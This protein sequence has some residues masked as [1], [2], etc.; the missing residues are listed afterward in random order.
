MEEWSTWYHYLLACTLPR[1]LEAS[2][3]PLLESL[4]TGFIA[5]YPNGVHSAPYKTFREDTLLTLGR[6]LMDRSCWEGTE[7][8]V[9]RILH[10]SNN[11]PARIW[12]W[13]DACGDFSS[14]M[15]FC[16][17]YLPAALI[18]NWLRS[19][20]A[21]KS[22]HWRAQVLV[23]MVGAHGILAGTVKWPSELKIGARP[24]VSWEWSHCLRPDLAEG[25]ASGANITQT[26]VPESVRHEVLQ[27]VRLHF[28]EDTYLDWLNSI[29]RVSYLYEE[30]S[31][32][33]TIFEELYVRRAH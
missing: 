6:C 21:I 28:S 33:P 19:V 22:P 1:A 15:F 32:I 17:K 24:S 7:I 5:I 30:L 13:W 4:I 16:L 12:A 2:L 18:G 25:D 14:S 3:N 27:L 11:N 10:R 20:L 31:E 26:F 29:S 23:W 8:A 9:G